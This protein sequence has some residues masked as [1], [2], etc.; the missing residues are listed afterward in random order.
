MFFVVDGGVEGPF[1]QDLKEGL[2]V[3]LAI[4]ELGEGGVFGVFVGEPFDCDHAADVSFF[5]GEAFVAVNADDLSESQI[6]LNLL[7]FRHSRYYKLQY[8]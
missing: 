1:G 8:K 2:A 7:F 6:F 3:E 5:F 4:F